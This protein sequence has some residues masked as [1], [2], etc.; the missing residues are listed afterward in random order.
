MA[1]SRE[2]WLSGGAMGAEA[3]SRSAYVPRAET[4]RSPRR[5]QRSCARRET[6]GWEGGVRSVGWPG[7]VVAFY[8]IGG[9][10]WPTNAKL[11]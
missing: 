6:P 3:V 8:R 10:R 4:H 2:T 11:E 5:W 9:G 1:R 7:R